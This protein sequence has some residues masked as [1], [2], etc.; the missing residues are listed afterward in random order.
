MSQMITGREAG[1]VLI[2]TRAWWK[3]PGGS[4]S[5]SAH[6]P[7]IDWTFNSTL[8]TRAILYLR[9]VRPSLSAP[10]ARQHLLGEPQ[11]DIASETANKAN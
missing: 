6:S 4:F 7:T 8:I 5:P 10:S 11:Q 1:R 9:L 3:F 2:Y